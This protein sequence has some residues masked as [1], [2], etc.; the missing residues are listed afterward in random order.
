VIVYLNVDDVLAAARA[1]LGREPDVRDAGLLAAAVA[2]PRAN[3]F[4]EDTYPDVHRKAAALLESLARNHALFDGNKRA[5]FASL[6]L[7]YRFNGYRLRFTTDEA[8]D[9]MLAV[10]TGGLDIDKIAELLAQH[11]EAT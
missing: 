1:A 6:V 4:G 2:R 7:F 3:V 9:L 10:A 8:F 11:V 5:A